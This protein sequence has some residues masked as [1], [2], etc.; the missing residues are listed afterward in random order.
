M[1]R[2]IRYLVTFLA[3]AVLVGPGAFFHAPAVAQEPEPTVIKMATLA[4]EGSAWMEILD[5][6][7][8]RLRQRTANRVCYRFYPGGVVGDEEVCIDKMRVGQIQAGG[9]TGHGLGRIVPSLR[10]MELPFLFKSY[11]ELDRVRGAIDAEIR[12]AYEQQGFVFAGWGEAGWDYFFSNRQIRQ[13]ADLRGARPWLWQ[14]DNV[15]EQFYRVVGAEPVP[16][17]LPDVLTSL[18][19]NL[20]DTIYVSP[21]ASIAL[22]WYPRTR[23]VTDMELHQIAAGVL[24]TRTCLD[25]LPAE[26]RT[27]VLEET[28][29][30]MREIIERSRHDHDESR[31]ILQQR[32]IRFLEVPPTARAE[33]EAVG[34]QVADALTG[35]MVPAELL[36]RV[37]AILTEMRRH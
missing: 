30:A 7:N 29:R 20:I 13:P 9:F 5:A 1:T 18:Q 28:A 27:A 37:R 32:G 31:R 26:H 14:G 10:V 24:I 25:S 22:Q 36:G 16:L 15:Y 19:T 23:F 3:L 12:A 34:T 21:L 2:L 11:E 6:M 33:F 35:S 17:A 8:E 4:P